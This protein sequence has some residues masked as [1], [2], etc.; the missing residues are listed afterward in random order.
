MIAAHSNL[1]Y[2]HKFAIFHLLPIVSKHFTQEG[3]N[4]LQR[5]YSVPHDSSE[6]KYC[7][8]LFFL[9]QF[10][11]Y[12]FFTVEVHCSLSRGIEI[13]WSL[14]L[15][16]DWIPKLVLFQK[17][18]LEFLYLYYYN[19]YRKLKTSNWQ[20]V[21]IYFIPLEHLIPYCLSERESLWSQHSS[22]GHSVWMP[23]VLIELNGGNFS[24]NIFIL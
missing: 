2:L 5:G 10:F 19:D 11:S 22:G 8:V 9:F 12:M 4:T 3:C 17:Q 18:P 21:G 15:P 1:G 13:D 14:A 6:F 7:I 23:G 16:R 24:V 20:W